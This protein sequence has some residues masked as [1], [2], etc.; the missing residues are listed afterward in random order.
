LFKEDI[1]DVREIDSYIV[2]RV[3]YSPAPIHKRIDS[4]YYQH[5][6]KRCCYNLFDFNEPCHTSVNACIWIC[7]S[8]SFFALFVSS[9]TITTSALTPLPS[10]A[11]SPASAAK[12][13]GCRMNGRES[14]PTS[15]IV[16]AS[17]VANTGRASDID[18]YLII[19]TDRAIYKE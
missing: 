8:E 16:S 17:I 6:Y 13:N 14:I 10:A 3:Q 18:L 19:I 7:E 15:I 9:S 12:S 5:R 11:I 4:S 1:V 2:D